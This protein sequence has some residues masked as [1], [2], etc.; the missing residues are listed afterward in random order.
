MSD[1]LAFPRWSM[2][3]V[4]LPE[5]FAALQATMGARLHRRIE[6]ASGLPSYGVAQ[7]DLRLTAGS[8]FIDRL[9]HVFKT[10]LMI[11]V[12]GNATVNNLNL[13]EAA[14][15]ASK[16]SLF[17]QVC[18]QTVEDRGR[19]AFDG[20][21]PK[22]PRERYEAELSLEDTKDDGR[23]SV[24]LAE[25]ERTD[26]GWQMGRY[27]PPLLRVG[28]G[29][30]PFLLDELDETQKVLVWLAEELDERRNEA[31]RG[32]GQGSVLP[33]AQASVHR[34]RALL[35]DHGIP[36]GPRGLALHPYQLFSALR[37][38]YIELS[39][40]EGSTPGSRST[41]YDH[42][43]LDPSFRGLRESIGKYVHRSRMLAPRLDFERRDHLFM[44][45]KV[46]P[47][48]LARAHR[49]YLVVKPGTISLEGVK[50][51]SPRR[52]AEVVK[53]SLTGVRPLR[54]ESETLSYDFGYDH[55][56]AFYELKTH[57]THETKD[58]RQEW[59]HA[60]REKA[61]CFQARPGLE[62]VQAALV[63]SR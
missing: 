53:R 3:Q 18:K 45:A 39:L 21:G 31:F 1:E 12:P 57:D 30:S 11:D 38:L 62:G 20:D 56:V 2:G 22:V 27:C 47:D 59:E 60:L 5:Q 33:L 40:L 15:G 19:P 55:G 51:A 26:I 37:N 48:E 7:L 23:E 10:G 29:V 35:A 54:S 41:T 50:L 36:G 42:D 17:F 44:T 63:W 16:V 28:W 61:L 32:G 43:Q 34:M 52:I 24:K 8:C 25:L 46:F 14:K 49:I 9:T 13:E 4:L 58:A 6:I